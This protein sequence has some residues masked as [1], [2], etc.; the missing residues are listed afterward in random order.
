MGSSTILVT[1]A[2]GALG[3][4]VLRRLIV[5]GHP[6]I[7][8]GTGTPEAL[9]GLAASTAVRRVDFDDEVTL[10]AAF[11]DIGRLLI[12]STDKLGTPGHRQRQHAAAL[13][14]AKRNGVRHVAY[15]SMP[16][17]ERS[18]AI[19]FAPDHAA[20]KQA[21]R[22]SGLEYTSLRNSWYQE[23]LLGYLPAVVRD[24]TWFTA[25][26]HGRIAYVARADAAAVAARIL[27]S[28]IGFGEVDV[29]GPE[30]LTVPEM[31]DRVSEAIGRSIRVEHVG[32]EQLALELVRQ[33]VA[34]AVIPMVAAT[35]A[36][37]AAGHFNVT[38]AASTALLGQEPRSLFEFFRAQ[39]DVLRGS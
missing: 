6:N 5:A 21:L 32:A 22:L 2:S 34:P 3:S 17:P 33:G 24:G 16:W 10:D 19:P 4:L 12:I 1:G 18:R 38:P 29:A 14:A 28:D 8:A 13:I 25:A 20:I 23:N 36:N 15:T 30:S 39:A 27:G 11:A 7:V 31:A 26:G 37:Q 9:S 35:E